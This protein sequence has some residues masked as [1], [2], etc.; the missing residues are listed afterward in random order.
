MVH[1][2]KGAEKVKPQVGKELTEKD[3]AKMG[4]ASHVVSV[5]Q[6]DVANDINYYYVEDKDYKKEFGYYSEPESDSD[7]D[8][9]ET[10]EDWTN[11]IEFT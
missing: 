11:S 3:I 9:Y 10:E 5:D 2:E 1:D 6:Y 4:E 8:E 7:V